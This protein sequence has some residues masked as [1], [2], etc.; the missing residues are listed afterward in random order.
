M[1]GDGPWLFAQVTRGVGIA[2]IVAHVKAAWS[3]A[4][5]RTAAG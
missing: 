4:T 5:H 2:E 3:R 1:R